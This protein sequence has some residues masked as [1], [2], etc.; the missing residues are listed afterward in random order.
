MCQNKISIS[1]I[2]LLIFTFA[3]SLLTT[4]CDS[5][6]ASAAETEVSVLVAEDYSLN[7]GT[8][9][10]NG[11]E[12]NCYFEISD[13]TIHFFATDE[14]LQTFCNALA[15]INSGYVNISESRYNEWCNYYKTNWTMPKTYTMYVDAMNNIEIQFDTAYNEVDGSVVSS[16]FAIYIDEDNFDYDQCRFTRK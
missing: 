7:D 12:N 11:D 13:G 16:S 3:V 1:T 6:S 14:Q 5:Q 2:C 9:Y 4:G 8:F 15:L 10:L